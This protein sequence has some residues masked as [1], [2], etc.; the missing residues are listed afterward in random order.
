MQAQNAVTEQNSQATPIWC[1]SLELGGIEST[2]WAPTYEPG[3]EFNLKA[4]SWAMCNFH[5]FLAGHVL[6]A[7]CLTGAVIAQLA[8]RRSHNPKVVS[9]ILTHRISSC[10]A[11]LA[12]MAWKSKGGQRGFRERERERECCCCSG[13]LCFC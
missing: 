7:P 13:C 3:A 4:S 6:L 1:A 5:E 10:Q 11:A 8:A 12:G 2:G 9:S